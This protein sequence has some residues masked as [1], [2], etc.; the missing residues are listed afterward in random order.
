MISLK[1]RSAY[2]VENV[3]KI[4]NIFVTFIFVEYSEMHYDLVMSKIRA[5]IVF[6]SKIWKINKI[7]VMGG[8]SPQAL[9]QCPR[10][11]ECQKLDTG[12]V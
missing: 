12:A 2:I 11:D 8:F 3:T 1:L 5:K 9:A 7:G 10:R 4:E 6:C